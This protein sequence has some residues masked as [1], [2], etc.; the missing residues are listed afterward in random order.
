M[1][2]KYPEWDKGRKE[3]NDEQ[4]QILTDRLR[5]VASEK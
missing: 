2:K 4:I 3:R 5:D 1:A